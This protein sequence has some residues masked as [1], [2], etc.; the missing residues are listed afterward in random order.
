MPTKQ[1]LNKYGLTEQDYNDILRSQGGVCPIC[2]KVPTCIDHF[3][4]PGYNEL[5]P[6]IKRQYVRGIVCIYCNREFLMREM[7]LERAR[8]IVKYLEAFDAKL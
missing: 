5:P 6:E 3:H 8:N 1:T 4:V 7:T 2:Y